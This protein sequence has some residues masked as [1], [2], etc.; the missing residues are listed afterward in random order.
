MRHFTTHLITLNTL[1][2]Y[3]LF[4]YPQHSNKLQ[5]HA[6][7]TAL[8]YSTVSDSQIQYRFF[9]YLQNSKTL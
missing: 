6:L 2:H 3:S 4:H 8:K 9:H 5:L 1:V 7:P